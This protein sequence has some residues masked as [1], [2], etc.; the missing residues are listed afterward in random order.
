MKDILK[1]AIKA[2]GMNMPPAKYA[3]VFG[4]DERLR[5]NVLAACKNQVLSDA[6]E[7]GT[8]RDH[9]VIEILS[10]AGIVA[11]RIILAVE[12]KLG[13][14]LQ[15][16]RALSLI[17]AYLKIS[18]KSTASTKVAEVTRPAPVIQRASVMTKAPPV[19]S[20]TMPALFGQLLV[21]GN[22]LHH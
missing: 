10:Q 19:F 3:K 6:I 2:G 18:G 14:K 8:I 15:R 17:K 11:V 13:R 9:R 16:S 4:N 7:A 20:G 22:Q 12:K 21:P 5:R 1:K